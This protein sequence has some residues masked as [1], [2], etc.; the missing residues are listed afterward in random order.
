MRVRRLLASLLIVAAVTAVASA[1]A[2]SGSS[3]LSNFCDRTQQLTASQQDRV[4]RFAAVVRDELAATNSGAVLI[5]RSGLDLSRFHIRYSH[6][7][8]A[9]RD[10]DATWTARQLYYACDEERPRIYDQG[11]AGF[12]MGIDNPALGYISIVKLPSDP[13]QMF[14]VTSL[15]KARAL[16]LLAA[17]YSANAYAY[18]LSYQNCNQWVMEILAAA[19]GNLPDGDD[20][21]ERAQLWL[22]QAGYAP[23]PVAVNSHWLMFASSFVPLLHL[24]D[25]PEDDRYAMKLKI[26]LPA[27]V[28]TFVQEKF[29]TS[30]RVE[31]CHDGKRVV[32]HRG[33]SPIADG[34]I[35][36]EGDR[37][38]DLDG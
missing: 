30:E 34:C 33:W 24:D 8:I 37:I 1:N 25:H 4:L 6:T 28:E 21:R 13:A 15:D 11:V 29:P 19:W 9:W 36:G 38:I 14:K 22:R 35:P 2:A 20:L 23:E 10:E 32:V 16:R 17:S 7:A 12:A 26:S 3:A 18:G 5:S 31:I 27:T